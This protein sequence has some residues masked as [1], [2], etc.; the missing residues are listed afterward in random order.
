MSSDRIIRVHLLMQLRYNSL[1]D[2]ISNQFSV[3]KHPSF[4]HLSEC[5]M[6][7]IVDCVICKNPRKEG[8]LPLV[9]LGEKRSSGVN[10]ASVER[11]DETIVTVPG[12]QVHKECQRIHCNSNK[13]AQAKKQGNKRPADSSAR[14]VLR[15]E[16]KS[17]SFT[18]DCLFCGSA[19]NFEQQKKRG[20]E[21]ATLSRKDS[22]MAA[23]SDRQ[24]TDTVKGR[25]LHF[26]DLPAAD[27]MYHQTCSVNF[28][29]GRQIPAM[30]LRDEP[31]TK[32][33]RVGRPQ[34]VDQT[35][36][37]LEVAQFLLENDDER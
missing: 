35:E 21:I 14:S 36:A 31:R 27:A 30:F 17:F 8:N 12:H 2:P 18:S 20:A 26:H 6:E 19:L 37:F 13:I 28:C 24:D 4:Q 7:S 10:R 34:D 22:V 23:C 29:T 25:I 16:E 11:N 9:T 15:S 3:F 32:E 33:E 1:N 5:K